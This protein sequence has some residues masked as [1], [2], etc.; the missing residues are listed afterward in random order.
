MFIESVELNNFRNYENLKI[1][2]DPGTNLLWGMNAQGKTNILESLYLC[3][4]TKS[5]RG[6]KDKDMV[7]LGQDEGHIRMM[8]MKNDNEIRID[9]HLKKQRAKGIAINGQPIK[10]A[11][12]LFG[13][14]SMVFFSPEDLNII[15]NGPSERRR[16]IDLELSQID[17]LYLMNL[18]RYQKS[19][20]QRN[21][22]L[23]EIYFRPELI[24]ELDVWDEQLITY[25]EAVIEKRES[26][27]ETLNEIVKDLHAGITGGSEKIE[28]KYEPSAEKGLLRKKIEADRNR[29]LKNQS[30]GSGPHRDDLG[31]MINGMDARLFGSQGQQRTAALSLK[32]SEIELL[33]RHIHDN[34]ILLLDDVLSELDEKRQ[35]Y[36]LDGIKETQTFITCTGIDELARSH[37]KVDRTFHV[38]SGG[39][40]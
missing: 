29:D 33:K 25:G 17:R 23:H 1:E 28:I 22:L 31:V 27:I 24:Q 34:P 19:L 18:T 36:L 37:F 2:F 7:R 9:M 8:I 11:A 5:H 16:F 12:D 35:Q 13:L 32:L 30:T 38:V 20:M 21:K 4:T 3:G 10:R 39:V 14:V 6:S 26:F 40:E 15:K